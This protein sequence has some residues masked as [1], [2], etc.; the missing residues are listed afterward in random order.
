[1]RIASEKVWA[2]ADGK[3]VEDGN[4][5][6]AFLVAS[7]GHPVPDKK[8]AKFKDVDVKK[9]FKDAVFDR[10]GQM[11]P[12]KTDKPTPPVTMSRLDTPEDTKAA[13]EAEAKAAAERAAV[14]KK[15]QDALASEGPQPTNR[16]EGL[17]VR[18]RA[19]KKRH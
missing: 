13:A 17:K 6:A 9:F 12:G 16:E 3:L 19:K 18:K 7:K 8:L 15:K 2:T 10:A 11:E 1:M 4:E 5:T 14:L